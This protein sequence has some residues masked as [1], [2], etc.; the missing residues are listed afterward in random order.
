[1]L[2][3]LT[4]LLVTERC[5]LNCF[6]C[7]RGEKHTKDMS[8]ADFMMAIGQVQSIHP[9]SGFVLT[10]G[11]PTMNI[12][13]EEMLTRLLN[14]TR[15]AVIVNSNGT[16]NFYEGIERYNKFDNLRV[17]FSI[18]GDETAH[19]RI[20]G[21][22]TF[23]RIRKNLERLRNANMP[24]WVSTVVAGQNISSIDRLR[25]LM[26]EFNVQKW[27][28]N[29]VLPFGCGSN[30]S[31]ISIE[32]WNAFVDEMIDKTPLRLGIKKLFDFSLLDKIDK[33]GILGFE[34]V[35]FKKHHRNCGC[36]HRK[37]Y[38]YPD[39]VVYG[40]A[41]LTTYPMGNLHEANLDA[42]EHSENAI[43]LREYSLVQDSPCRLCRYVDI[44]HGG[45][46]GMS[47]RE[48]GRLGVGDIRCP[49]FMRLAK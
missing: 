5:N 12:A 44:C 1:M 16:T 23:S 2:L 42:I 33:D 36:G 3:L 10:G 35:A 8:V 41:C 19:D 22:G 4:Y 13:F 46:I 14:A 40:C 47:V 6:H 7:I 38:I 45:C 24:I 21:V 18:D 48:F 49:I 15:Q 34:A 26:V 28:I 29:P 20:R 25:D 9:D 11:E 37:L 39:M 30:M 32:K 31:P 27:H 17:Q 43:A